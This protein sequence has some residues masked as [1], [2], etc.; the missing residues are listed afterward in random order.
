VW[1]CA[2]AQ[3]LAL[4]RVRALGCMRALAWRW[5]C[6]CVCVAAGRSAGVD[7]RGSIRDAGL[8]LPP[9]RPPDSSPAPS[10]PRHAQ[11]SRWER[12]RRARRDS[13]S[14]AAKA[15]AACSAGGPAQRLSQAGVRERAAGG[16]VGCQVQRACRDRQIRDS[17]MERCRSGEPGSGAPAGPWGG[18]SRRQADSDTQSADRRCA[19]P[20][21]GSRAAGGRDPLLFPMQQ[22]RRLAAM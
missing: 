14:R 7:P 5:E 17:R 19:R 13:C 8:T 10:F 3:A 11:V 18:V 2:C 1:G 6:G 20:P 12:F 15:Q 4:A 21:A 9:T 16:P 22:R